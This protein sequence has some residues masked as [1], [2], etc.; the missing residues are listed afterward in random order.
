MVAEI[1]DDTSMVVTSMC[2]KLER[3]MARDAIKIP[4]APCMPNNKVQSKRNPAGR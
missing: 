4:M 1:T 2:T 3:D